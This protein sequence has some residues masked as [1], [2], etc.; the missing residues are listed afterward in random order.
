MSATAPEP[1]PSTDT[2]TPSVLAVVVA[3]DGSARWLPG[4][5][6]S[7]AHQSYPRLGVLAVDDASTDGS[8]DVLLRAVGDRRV[9]RSEQRRGFAASIRDALDRPAARGA[10]FVLVLDPR[11]SLDPDVVA[12][13]V[14]AAVGIGVVE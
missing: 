1:A 6:R 8:H 14:E 3:T 5:L 9:I 13:L 10:D 4:C 12:R 2:P 11:A 7:L